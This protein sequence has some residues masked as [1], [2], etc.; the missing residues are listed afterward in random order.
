MHRPAVQPRAAGQLRAPGALDGAALPVPAVRAVTASL[1]LFD[2]QPAPMLRDRPMPGLRPYQEEAISRISSCL[3]ESASTLLVLPTGTGKTRTAATY[4]QRRGGRVLWLAHRHELIEQGRD[5]LEEVTGRACSIEKADQRARGTDVVVA[6]VQTLKGERLAEF[7]RR[8]E[9]ELIVTDEAHHS[10]S[11]SYRAIYDAFPR[12]KHLGLTATPDR[13]DE[14]A[15]GLVFDSVAFVYEIRDAIKDG[16]LCPIR[17][18][19]VQVDAIDLHA[20]GTVAGDL[21]QGEL[22]AIMSA[23]EALHGVVGAAREHAGDRR[24]IV[25]TTSVE[26]AHRLA[27]IMNRYKP[28]SARAVDGATDARSRSTILRDHKAGQYQYLFNVGVLTEGYDDPQVSCIVLGRPTS[29][30]AL[31]AQM[32]G[33]GLRI[34][35]GKADC[36]LV[37]LAG[38]AG[39]HSLV[40]ATDILA[41]NFDDDTMA[42]AK[43]LVA[44]EP[45]MLAEEA[46]EKAAAEMERRRQ[47]E[48][49]RRAKIRGKVKTIAKAVDPF[50]VFGVRDPGAEQWS[51]AYGTPA[52]DAQLNCL[53]SFKVP[54]PEGCTKQQASALISTA[55]GRR[56]HGLCTFKQMATL[57][58]YG[59]DAR[60]TSFERASEIMTAIAANGWRSLPREQMA[61]FRERQ[62]G[63]EG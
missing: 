37:D 4:V 8:F 62:P 5:S 47:A 6:S 32:A 13:H 24:T 27:E 52:S 38:N 17:A 19:S 30:R 26:N 23:E 15:M 50:G 61:A 28:D 53:L 34:A 31:Y 54:V 44:K 1:S 2:R 14:R 21:N 55:I 35:P 56:Q 20:V 45:G 22:D 42:L 40:T 11:P 63:E 39:R 3:A 9:P 49:A 18:L 12:A 57:Q 7:G 41:G 36:L 60:N 46:I 33:R 59:F 43:E 16:F 58:R 10:P 29:S 48:A 51:G 25:F